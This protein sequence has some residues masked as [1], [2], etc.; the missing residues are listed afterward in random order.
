[1]GNRDRGKSEDGGVKE[2]GGVSEWA[3]VGFMI[4]D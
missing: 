2:D 1:M 4:R 3:H